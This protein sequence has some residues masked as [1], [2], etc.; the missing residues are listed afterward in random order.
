LGLQTGSAATAAAENV[1]VVYVPRPCDLGGPWRKVGEDLTQV[2]ATSRLQ[3]PTFVSTVSRSL[4]VSLSLSDDGTVLS[5]ASRFSDGVSVFRR[6]TTSSPDTTVEETAEDATN[7]SATNNGTSTSSQS[8][9]WVQLGADIVEGPPPEF[10]RED[11]FYRTIG[12]TVLSGDGRRVVAGFPHYTDD[13]FR[14]RGLVGVYE[15]IEEE[16]DSD[17]YGGGNDDD[18]GAVSV[19]GGEW[20]AMGGD[21]GFFL[22][23]RSN[24]N[25][26]HKGTFDVSYD[27]SV[28]AIGD[29][30]HDGNTG[31]VRVFRYDSQNNTWSQ[32]GDDINGTNARDRFGWA[33]SLSSDGTSLAVGTSHA[34][35]GEGLVQ[36]FRYTEEDGSGS[37]GGGNWT[38]VG[39]TLRGGPQTDSCRLGE[40]LKL[41]SNATRFAVWSSNPL[42]AGGSNVVPCSEWVD[43]E[44]SDDD[45]GQVRVYEL[46]V[47]GGDGNGDDEEEEEWVQTGPGFVGDRGGEDFGVDLDLSGDGRTLSIGVSGGDRNGPESGHVVTYH[48]EQSDDDDDEPRGG[49]GNWTR[50]GDDDERRGGGGNWTRVGD[51]VNGT[52]GQMWLG[53]AVSLSYDGTVLAAGA[54]TDFLTAQERSEY[55]SG[56]VTVYSHCL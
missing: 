4:G 43:S 17:D 28:V 25:L 26:G 51:D 29:P 49:G 41:S 12:S 18:D 24:S 20:R 22:G 8:E 21:S 5:V 50:A 37:G 56:V 27:G 30:R 33:V 13:D 9:R 32:I 35:G 15:W 48:E 34:N 1:T 36:V 42:E 31:R 19:V 11:D 47:G 23:G 55:A 53:E 38:Q 44:A 16:R 52:A 2:N 3:R 54:P 7:S 40:T 10:R 46:V 45:R 6:M 14:W 39:N